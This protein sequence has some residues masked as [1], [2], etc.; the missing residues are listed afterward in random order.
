MVVPV[1]YRW[2]STMPQPVQTS[3]VAQFKPRKARRVES[4]PFVHDA[5]PDSEENKGRTFW[6]VNSTGDYG[7]DWCLGEALG[8]EA[9]KFTATEPAIGLIA[10][11]IGEMC[12]LGREPTGIELGF[13]SIIGKAALAG[14]RLQPD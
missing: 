5:D 11:V 14:L 9:L 2:N 12:R 3:A 8:K 1:D 7:L 10:I 6:H 13:A 4:L